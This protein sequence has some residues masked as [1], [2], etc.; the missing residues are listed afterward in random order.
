MRAQEPRDPIGLLDVSARRMK[1]D[2]KLPVLDRKEEGANPLRGFP[3]DLAFDRDPAIAAGAAGIRRSLGEI[4]G[5][6]F[7]ESGLLDRCFFRPQHARDQK[8][9][10]EKQETGKHEPCGLRD[11]GKMDAGR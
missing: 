7:R 10:H 8:Q 9:R 4:D 5:Q 6:L 1:V 11:G 2:R 3:I